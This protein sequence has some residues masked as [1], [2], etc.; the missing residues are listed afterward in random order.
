MPNN[1]QERNL[2]QHRCEDLFVQCTDR[3]PS[4]CVESLRLCRENC[5]ALSERED[6]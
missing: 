1:P 5:A 2:C 4:G 6:A 3:T